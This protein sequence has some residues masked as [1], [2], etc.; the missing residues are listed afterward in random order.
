MSIVAGIIECCG[1]QN[2]NEI[3]DDY[4]DDNVADDIDNDDFG[5]DDRKVFF[6]QV[7]FWLLFVN[8]AM[9]VIQRSWYFSLYF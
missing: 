4:A 7:R 1:P 3:N 8:G 9:K 5:H 2:T 6:F